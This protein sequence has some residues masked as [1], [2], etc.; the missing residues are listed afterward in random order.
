MKKIVYRQCKSNGVGKERMS[1][2][3][4]KFNQGKS[5]KEALGGHAIKYLAEFVFV[6]KMSNLILKL[7]FYLLDKL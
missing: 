2:V 6:T 3:D 1:S 7:I 4:K 5:S